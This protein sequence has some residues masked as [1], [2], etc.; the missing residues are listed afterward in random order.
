V[1]PATLQKLDAFAR[2]VD[3]AMPHPLH[4][5]KFQKFILEAF[6][7]GDTRLEAGE[8]EQAV[9]RCCGSRPRYLDEWIREY[10]R[11]IELLEMNHLR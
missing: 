10:R 6:Q 2:T 1:H 5:R 4:R 11:G 3:W 7:Q 9:I 8:I